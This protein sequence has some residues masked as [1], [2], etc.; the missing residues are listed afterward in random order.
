VPHFAGTGR[1]IEQLQNKHVDGY[2]G[3][4]QS[5]SHSKNWPESLIA[6]GFPVGF[7]S[8]TIFPYKK[9]GSLCFG[10]PQKNG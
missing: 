6:T 8:P 3:L 5:L 10:V 9:T 4:S 7:S 2:R 1:I